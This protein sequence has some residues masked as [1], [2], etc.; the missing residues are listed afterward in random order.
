MAA[1]VTGRKAPT[2]MCPM[3]VAEFCAPVVTVT[4]QLMGTRPIFTRASLNALKSNGNISHRKATLELGYNPPPIQETITDTVKW[5][6]DNGYID[7]K[8]VRVKK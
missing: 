3:G 5:F 1:E 4:S 8:Q 2:M 6:M 7:K